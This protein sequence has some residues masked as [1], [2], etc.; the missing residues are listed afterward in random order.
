MAPPV[1]SIELSACISVVFENNAVLKDGCLTHTS[2]YD[3]IVYKWTSCPV[4][5]LCHQAGCA[6]PA[7]FRSLI[8]PTIVTLSATSQMTRCCVCFCERLACWCCRY[9]TASLTSGHRYSTISTVYKEMRWREETGLCH[10]WSSVKTKPARAD[11]RYDE[12]HVWSW[13]IVNSKLLSA[14]LNETEITSCLPSSEKNYDWS[15]FWSI[16]FM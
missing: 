9:P 15:H 2:V 6:S 14:D 4:S 5:L 11:S 10:L 1:L 8:L 13:F 7:W 16:V 12:V 3:F